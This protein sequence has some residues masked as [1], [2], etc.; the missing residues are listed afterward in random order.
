M[1]LDKPRITE[2]D[3][4]ELGKPKLVKNFTFNEEPK[5]IEPYKN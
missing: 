5:P 1:E 3:T 2:P 4:P